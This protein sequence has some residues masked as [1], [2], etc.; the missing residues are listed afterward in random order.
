LLKLLLLKSEVSTSKGVGDV[1]ASGYLA[2]GILRRVMLFRPVLIAGFS[3]GAHALCAVG[4][5]F[6]VCV[7]TAVARV[8]PEVVH[9]K[10]W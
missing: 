4:H 1:C 2:T 3:C 10:E 7:R 8:Q 9:L 6:R 5:A